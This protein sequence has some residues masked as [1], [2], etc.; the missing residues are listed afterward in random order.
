M[1]T[2]PETVAVARIDSLGCL[3]VFTAAVVGSGQR[4]VADS[5]SRVPCP[6]NEPVHR[7]AP[8]YDPDA[9]VQFFKFFN[10]RG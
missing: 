3:R 7:L 8:W 5:E 10:H 6:D 9:G 4:I 2:A 1:A